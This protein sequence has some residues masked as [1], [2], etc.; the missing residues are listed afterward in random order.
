MIYPDD[1]WG[2]EGEKLVAVYTPGGIVSH[3]R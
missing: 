2:E 1:L 3:E